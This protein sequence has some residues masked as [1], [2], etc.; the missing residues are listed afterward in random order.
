[1]SGLAGRAAILD[2][3]QFL[4]HLDHAGVDLVRPDT[5]LIATGL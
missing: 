4:E 3:E 1:M 5:L 2:A